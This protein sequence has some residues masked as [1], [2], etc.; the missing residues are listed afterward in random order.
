MAQLKA[1]G[2]PLFPAMEGYGSAP[3]MS[4]SGLWDLQ[5]ERTVLIN[6]YLK[7]W[8]AT[9][10]SNEDAV[11]DAIIM[12]VAPHAGCQHGKFRNYVGYT[13]PFNA[14]D[15]SVGVLPVTRADKCLDSV[16][17]E[18]VSYNEIDELVH[19]EYDPE[20]IHGGG[21][22]VQ[23]VCRRFEEEKIIAILK[24]LSSLLGS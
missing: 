17:D 4:V 7:R 15:Y 1:T 18:F 19:K 23:V 9:A 13:S 3:D 21:V 10:E 14:L 6:N 11:M 5:A 12:P 2:E 16:E 8:N 24:H 22:S 20:I